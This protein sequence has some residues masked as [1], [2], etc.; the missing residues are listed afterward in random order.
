[1]MADDQKKTKRYIM[2]SNIEDT[3]VS[4]K[5]LLSIQWLVAF[6]DR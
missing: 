6:L 5:T 2:D 1:M 4:A 3:A